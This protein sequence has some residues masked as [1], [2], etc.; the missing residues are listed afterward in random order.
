MKTN[1]NFD[2]EELQNRLDLAA[3]YHLADF[4]VLVILFGTI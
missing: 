1:K 4:M 3:A 2:Y